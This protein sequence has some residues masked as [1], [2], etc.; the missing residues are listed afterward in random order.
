LFVGLAPAR[1]EDLLFANVASR[2]HT[3]VYDLPG[4]PSAQA[5]FLTG[6]IK[7]KFPQAEILDADI[8]GDPVLPFKLRYSNIPCHVAA[9]VSFVTNPRLD[10]SEHGLLPDVPFDR[11]LLAPFHDDDDPELA[12]TLDYIRKHR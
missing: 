1:A 6:A 3:V 11:R 2:V 5:A 4:V 8:C 12:F 7:R 10:P 9:S